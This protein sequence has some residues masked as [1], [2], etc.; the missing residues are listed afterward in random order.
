MSD[1]QSDPATE[2]EVRRRVRQMRD[3]EIVNF[4]RETV[5][6]LDA[7]ADRLEVFTQDNSLDRGER[8][9]GA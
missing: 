7:L 6:R 1:P 9:D 5:I 4:V 8:T 2:L 3:E